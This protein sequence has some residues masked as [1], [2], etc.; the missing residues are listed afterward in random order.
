MEPRHLSERS[1]A[2]RRGATTTPDTQLKGFSLTHL[3]GPGCTGYGDL[4]ILPLVGGLPAGVDPGSVYEPLTHATEVGTAGYYSLQSGATGSMI[5][6]ELTATL[7]SS[8]ARFT[9]PATSNANILIKLLGS[10]N[11]DKGSSATI[12]GTNEVQGST[13]RAPASAAS[14][15]RPLSTSTSS[16]TNLSPPRKSSR[17]PRRPSIASSS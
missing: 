15:I 5:T 17:T 13:T 10:Q 7:H 4:P 14:P 16:S 3:S 9:Y 1:L 11:G 2:P 8:M 12:I 6:T